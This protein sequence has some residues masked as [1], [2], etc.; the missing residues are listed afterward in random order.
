MSLNKKEVLSNS[1]PKKLLTRQ[2]T[3]ELLGVSSGTLAVWLCC[4]RYDLPYIKIGSRVM[5]DYDD[6]LQF[7]DKSRHYQKDN[8]KEIIPVKIVHESAKSRSELEE[9]NF[10]S[11]KSQKSNPTAING[12]LL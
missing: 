11:E 9:G 2:E 5:Y 1:L 3:A 12:S 6:I 8:P 4:K 7:I 10:A